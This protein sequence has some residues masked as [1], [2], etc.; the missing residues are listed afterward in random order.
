MKCVNVTK[1]RNVANGWRR[2]ACG[3]KSF[4]DVIQR[5]EVKMRSADY[6]VGDL[7]AIFQ[8]LRSEGTI[9]KKRERD[10]YEDEIRQAKRMTFVMSI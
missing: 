5:K 9:D 10:N 1:T 4:V 8:I 2:K 3:L 7:S 6:Y